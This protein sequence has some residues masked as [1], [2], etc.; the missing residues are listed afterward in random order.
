MQHDF[1]DYIRDMNHD[2]KVDGLDAALFHEMLDKDQVEEQVHKTTT[3]HGSEPWTVHHSIAKGALLFF[4]GLI[5]VLALKGLLPVNGFTAV[6]FLV[7]V[8]CFLRTLLL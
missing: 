2:G 4:F 7:S 8:V 5:P 1:P 6:L 3:H